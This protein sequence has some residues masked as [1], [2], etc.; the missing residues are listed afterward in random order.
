MPP[1]KKGRRAASYEMRGGSAARGI[2]YLL[3]AFCFALG[4]KEEQ[5]RIP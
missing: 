1:L 5:K 4:A 3:F 2:C